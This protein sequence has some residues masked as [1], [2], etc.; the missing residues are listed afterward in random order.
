MDQFKLD[1]FSKE[2][3]DVS[4]IGIKTLLNQQSRDIII[5]MLSLLGIDKSIIA[6]S[7]EF[8]E[9]F[10]KTLQY[11]TQ[12][13]RDGVSRALLKDL[14]TNVGVVDSDLVYL[15]W[16]LEENV[17]TIEAKNLFKYWEY[18]WYDAS[19][20]ALILYIE[21]KEVVLITDRGHIGSAFFVMT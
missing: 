6:S 19:D 20:E 11:R 3:C 1:I 9:S 13:G 2:H 5:E 7:A 4:R 12:Y 21:K 17:D 8:F 18:I 16:S 14:L 10:E 15:I